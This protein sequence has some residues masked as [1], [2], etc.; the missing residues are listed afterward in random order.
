MIFRAFALGT[1]G[2]KRKQKSLQE[3]DVLH[4]NADIS[5][6][7]ETSSKSISKMS[8]DGDMARYKS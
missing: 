5:P 4:P 8:D 3:R 6:D 1:K 2:W 7:L